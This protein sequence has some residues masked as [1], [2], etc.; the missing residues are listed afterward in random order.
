[1]L[2]TTDGSGTINGNKSCL[3][4]LARFRISRIAGSW[5][6]RLE[7]H[8]WSQ[9]SNGGKV[10]KEVEHILIST[11]WGGGAFG[12]TR[13]SGLLGSLQLIADLLLH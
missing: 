7:V 12:I 11:R 13:F 5:Y 8:R 9:F 3:L 2:V 10:A 1:M 6:Q 4:N